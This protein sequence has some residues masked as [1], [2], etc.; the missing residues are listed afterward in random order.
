M[1]DFRKFRLTDV[2]NLQGIDL[3]DFNG[4]LATSPTGLGIYRVAEYITVGNQRIQ[5]NNT[6]AF[7]KITLMVQIL[8]ERHTW[9]QKYATLRDFISVN[10]KKG[11]RL[12][13][14]TEVG[15]RYVKCDINIVD[16]TEKD[17][18]NL[19]IK[20]EIQ[21]KSL[22]LAD[23]QATSVQQTISSGNL[24][25]FSEQATDEYY[26]KFALIDGVEN[27][28]PHPYPQ[29]QA[30][31]EDAEYPYYA[32]MFGTGALQYAD[33]VN[34]GGENTP[35]LIRL[36]GRAVNPFIK[37]KDKVT[38]EIVQSVKFNNLIVQA[39]YYLEINS[40]ADDT[41]I[42]LVNQQTGEHFD[43]ENFAD[44]TTNVYLYLPQGRYTIEV[45]DESE[46]N[47][48]YARVDFA[49]QYYGG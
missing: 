5:T 25:E 41:H 27:D 2:N 3:N 33:L 46:T 39:G 29:T 36:F 43:R 23:V 10:I 6:S 48:C 30:D 12:Y 1:A 24:F 19:P 38:G 44:L 26:A 31:W 32:T 4:Y 15:T 20:L 14:T 9:E 28:T 34:L 8:G 21:P 40:S 18:A 17:Y 35:L 16:K 11:F 7:Q 13:Y 49:N 42:H 45:S 22:W 47:T 37:L